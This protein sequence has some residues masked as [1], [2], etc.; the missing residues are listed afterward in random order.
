MNILVVED[1]RVIRQSLRQIIERGSSG[2]FR[3]VGEAK[4][5]RAAL[6]LIK[7]LEQ[8]PD[9]VITDIRMPVMDGLTFIERLQPEHGY[10]T[11]VILSGY[12]D[13]AYAK[14]AMRLGVTDYLLKPVDPEELMQV[15]RRV[16]LRRTVF[17]NAANQWIFWLRQCQKLASQLHGCLTAL[18]EKRLQ[19]ELEQLRNSAQFERDGHL[20]TREKFELF[21]GLLEDEL[22]QG[23]DGRHFE[24]GVMEF[25]D[26]GERNFQ[27]L[28]R[29]L[30]AMMEEIRVR[31]NWGANLLVL[32]AVEFVEKHYMIPNMRLQ[33]L[34]DEMNVSIWYLSRVFKQETGKNFISYLMDYRLQRAKEL[35]ADPG[36]RLQTVAER[37][38]YP[39]YAHFSRI[40]K[41]KYGMTPSEFKRA[42][43]DA[44]SRGV[45]P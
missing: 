18:D 27:L 16:K 29:R 4:E 21:W 32:R 40:F 24:N 26:D 45:A 35:M 6:Q 10:I 43:E 20:S 33:Q 23:A 14:Q 22:R 34:A 36:A 17:E 9:V 5:G 41:K 31:R 39:E 3:V 42:M 28:Q 11:V 12:D 1:E 44:Q 13:F 30:L 19:S 15:L 38:G 25:T 8:A 2:E 37:V 7:E